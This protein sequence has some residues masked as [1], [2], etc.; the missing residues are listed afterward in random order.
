[1]N[2]DVSLLVGDG[3]VSF[4]FRQD[5][6]IRKGIRRILRKQLK[7]AQQSLRGRTSDSAD[8]RV[9]SARKNFKRVRAVARL[10]RDAI[11]DS[12]YRFVNETIRDAG[13]PLSEVRDAKVLVEALD[14]L[15]KCAGDSAADM[16]FAA[17]REVLTANQRVVREKVLKEGEAF[18]ATS[19]VVEE[20]LERLD[21]WTD[22]PNR[23]ATLGD[24]IKRVYRSG[25]KAFDD[26]KS[27]G[28]V[29]NLHEWRTQVKYLRY[30]LELLTPTWP[31]VGGKL[32]GQ[33]DELG[34][35]LGEDH[36]LAVLRATLAETKSDD[37]PA[38][39][40]DSIAELI[41]ERRKKL[42][43]EATAKGELLY[44]ER[45]KEFDQRLAS[46]WRKWGRNP[47]RQLATSH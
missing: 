12:T 31:K 40:M 14:K 45:P 28:S 13:R 5:E 29:E 11:G 37:R 30:Q 2:P 27:D 4:E 32:A 41:D 17:A 23:W 43:S 1:L 21:D 44:R 16:P 6:S 39:K 3:K 38:A 8:E 35:L 46:Y 15:K 24:G 26:T 33:A 10:V 7:S 18:A 19:A 25:R 22:V 20:T 47:K 9:H 42:Q 36:D 34:D